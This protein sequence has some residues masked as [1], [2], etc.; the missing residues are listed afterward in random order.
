MKRRLIPALSFGIV[1]ILIGSLAYAAEKK[2][3]TKTID[4]TT[5]KIHEEEALTAE[6][7]NAVEKKEHKYQD[8]VAT[9][10]V[11]SDYGNNKKE[12]IEYKK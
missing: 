4:R 10:K 6:L 1:V 3:N 7:L 12:Q 11:E 8:N 9:G 2:K 5:D